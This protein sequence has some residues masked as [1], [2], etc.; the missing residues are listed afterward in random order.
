[1]AAR[2]VATLPPPTESRGL[3][4]PVEGTSTQYYYHEVGANSTCWCPLCEFRTGTAK[5][6]KGL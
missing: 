6:T 2:S 5:L 4:L 3:W 1:M